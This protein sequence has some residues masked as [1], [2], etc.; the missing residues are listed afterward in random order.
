M[1]VTAAWDQRDVS[2]QARV[3]DRVLAAWLPMVMSAAPR[4]TQTADRLGMAPGQA[5]DREALRRFRPVTELEM[6]AGDDTGA[7]A[8][9][10][11]TE[12]QVKAHAPV[13]TLRR[14]AATIGG[15]GPVD[16]REVLLRDYRPLQLQRAGIDG[17]FWV[18]SSRTDLDRMHRAGARTAAVLGLTEDDVVV[19]AVRQAPDLA[20]LAT[21]H[22]ALGASLTA[23]HP[24]TTGGYD[25]VVAAVRS[26]RPSV[27]VVDVDE[28][29]TLGRAL[30]DA[31]AVPPGLRRVVVLG[32]P[33]DDTTRE[34][35]AGAFAATGGAVGI[36]AAWGPAE[37]RLLWAEC[38]PGSGLH[39]YP[40]L[41]LLEVVDPLTAEPVGRED[42]GELV[43]TSLGWHGTALV[44]FRTGVRVEGVTVEPC[45]SCGRTLP[46]LAGN[47]EPAAWQLPYTATDVGGV[48]DLRGIAAVLSHTPGVV[49]WRVELVR[50]ERGDHLRVEV[51]GDVAEDVYDLQDRLAQ[52]CGMVPEVELG[53][54]TEDV[55]AGVARVGGIFADLR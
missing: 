34:R 7:D 53:V 1:V 25:E 23:A 26:L 33:P 13:P 31:G 16:K 50:G 49:D 14:L 29:E 27:L 12:Q 52:V 36:L 19:S 39:T 32:P 51:A 47:L 22:L 3:R 5:R 4:W 24:R 9:V 15:E 2:E 28:V 38:A 48:V 6:L 35:M 21:V 46:R 42:E 44:R 10:A 40:D 18:A 55:A 30:V 37:S 17:R 8:V 11:P 54:P 20:H 41:E 43:L 45:P